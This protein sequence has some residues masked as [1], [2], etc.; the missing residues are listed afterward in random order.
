MAFELET[1]INAPI[2]KVFE[3]AS[4]FAYTDEIEHIEKMEKKT[5]GPV[6]V[7]TEFE[8]TRHI[9]GLKVNN[10]VKV[11]EYE[12]DARFSTES[13]QHKLFLKCMYTFSETDGGTH[14]KMK[15]KLKP[16]GLKNKLYK[17]LITKMIKKED[18]SQLEYLK[19]HVEGDSN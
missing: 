1:V 5:D 9:R 17:P 19:K 15:G 3:A 14:V 16:S 12:K 4:T 7:G 6:N 8:E 13:Q 2:D 11:T 18:G 10:I